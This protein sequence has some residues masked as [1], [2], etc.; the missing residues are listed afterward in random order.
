MEAY[1]DEEETENVILDNER[2]RHCKIFLMENWGGV[3]DVKLILH[4]KR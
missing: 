3:D 2:E 4:V 1:P